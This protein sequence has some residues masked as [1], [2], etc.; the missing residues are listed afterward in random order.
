MN[1]KISEVNLR[2]FMFYDRYFEKNKVWVYL[3]VDN[4][5]DVKLERHVKWEELSD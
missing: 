1:K 4:N 3:I 5:K 2:I